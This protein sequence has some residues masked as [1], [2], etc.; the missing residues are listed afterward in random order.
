MKN[1]VPTLPT[2]HFKAGLTEKRRQPGFWLTLE[3]TNATEIVA[4]SGFDWLLL[5][6]EHTALDVSQVVNHL[7]AAKG[8]TAEL[9]VRVPWN[10]PIIMK[11]LLDTGVRSFMIPFVGSD[12]LF[13]RGEARICLPPSSVNL[14][15]QANEALVEMYSANLF[16]D[17]K[18]IAKS[19]TDRF[20]VVNPATEEPLGDALPGR[21]R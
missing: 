8:G 3:S 18:T 11:R 7:G 15:R 14:E 2:N 1:P 4:G 20:E 10:D 17:G 19:S 5:D 13:S 12:T 16:I 21:S 6:M 9:V